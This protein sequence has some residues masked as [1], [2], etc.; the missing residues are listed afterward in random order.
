[1]PDVKCTN[2]L[3]LATDQEISVYSYNRALRVRAILQPPKMRTFALEPASV[4]KLELAT[5][6]DIC[7]MRAVLNRIS[8]RLAGQPVWPLG[9]RELGGKSVHALVGFRNGVRLQHINDEAPPHSPPARCLRAEAWKPGCRTAQPR[10]EKEAAPKALRLPERA[11][12][13]SW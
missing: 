6:F 4:C 13:S 1:M 10:I 3:Q 7:E 8:V 12:A 9:R 11:A 2:A 5:P